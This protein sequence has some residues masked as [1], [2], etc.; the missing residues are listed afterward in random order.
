MPDIQWPLLH[1]NAQG[2]A[3]ATDPTVRAR[4]LADRV[5]LLARHGFASHAAALLPEARDAVLELNDGE[6]F[7][8]LAISEAITC[9]YSPGTA[10]SLAV[11]DTALEAAREHRM[12]ELEAEAS[13]WAASYR[14]TVGIDEA[15]AIE[16][17]R[18]ALQHAGPACETTLPRALYAAGNQFAAAGLQDDAQLCYCN[19]MRLA[20]R[21]EDLQ[22]CHAIVTYPLL[23][24]LNVARAAHATGSLSDTVAAKLEERLR[25]AASQLPYAAKRAQI[26]VHLGEALRLR[27]RYAE[28]ARLLK[29]YMPQ[30]QTE[31]MSGDELL[32]GRS[33]LAVCM[34]HLR[35]ARAASQERND[36]HLALPGQ[37][38]HYS[39]AAL[40]SNLAE[41]EQLL[42]RPE[43]AA[44]LSA[45]AADA[46]GQRERYKTDQRTALVNADLHSCWAAAPRLFLVSRQ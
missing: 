45:R 44:R 10:Q 18:F 24:E 43:A 9:Y 12:P 23:I 30:G 21:A 16:H 14:P 37:M 1:R 2:L 46:W 11:F 26:Q 25:T 7:V 41:L 33:D 34:L 19:A 39:R 20:R 8:R 22:L 42:G 5:G 32:V 35:D 36:L 4:L 17:I 28:A 38:S 15:G 27:R 31:G 29:L 3:E 13:V 6:A 40:L